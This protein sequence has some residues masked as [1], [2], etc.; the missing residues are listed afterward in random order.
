MSV[1][2]CLLAYTVVVA[3]LAPPLLLRTAGDGQHPRLGLV[4][5]LS[6]IVSVLLSWAVAVV[7]LGVDVVR[8]L[9]ADQHLDLGRFRQLHDAAAGSYGTAVQVG[10]W[11]LAGL[12]VLAAVVA[13]WRL[14]RSLV[15]ARSVTHQHAQAAR[16]VGRRHDRHNA[17]V[18]DHPEPAAYSVAGNPHTIVLTQGIVA[19]LDEEQLAAVMAHERAHLRGRHHVLLAFTRALASV[20]PR[21]ELFATGAA[22]V[23]RLT[24]MIADDA[25]A[26]IYGPITVCEA[27]VTLA[28][29]HGMATVAAT[30]VGL[31]DRVRRLAE[32]PSPTRMNRVAASAAIAAVILGPMI[33]TLAAAGGIGVCALGS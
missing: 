24:E 28:D 18:L 25:A 8:D 12:A 7:F 13:V 17:V 5:W 4:A 16:M 30:E 27:L 19:T 23:A 29:S 32:P 14:C 11:T 22:Q 1:A 6:A 2:L 9:L 3:V 31:V 33:A 20:F 21:I 26:A 10:L 15:R